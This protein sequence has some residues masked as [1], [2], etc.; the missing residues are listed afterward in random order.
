MNT[1]TNVS[2]RHVVF[3]YVGQIETR[4]RLLKQIATLQDAGVNCE[5]VL[6]NTASKNP[7]AESLPFPVQVIPVNQNQSKLRSFLAQM[8]FCRKAARRIAASKADTVVCLALESLMAGVMAK[9]M[10]PNLRLIFDNNELHIESYGPGLKSLIWKPIHNYGIRRC[11]AIFHAEPNRMAHFKKNYPGADKEQRVLENFPFFKEHDTS[12]APPSPEIRVIYL[13]GFGEGRF[14]REII[15]AFAGF[16]PDIRLDIVGSGTPEFVASMNEHLN[17]LSVDHVRLLPAVKHADIPK[18][19]NDYHIGVALYR[20]TNLN[21]YY[22]APNKVYDYLMNGMPV[23]T[24]RYPGL[25]SVIEAN[26]VGVCI[27]EVGA[28]E[29]REAIDVICRE[30]RWENITPEI[31]RRYCWEHQVS[32]YLEVFGIS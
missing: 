17:S 15:D 10:R 19:L 26:R 31:R 32:D 14:T 2:A 23:I 9:R 6:G 13:G 21:N 24:N 8:A 30:R 5:V 12:H 7:D 29:I 20:N 4:G 16:P 22:C 25:M 3:A 28:T 27:D 1:T 11:D 18:V